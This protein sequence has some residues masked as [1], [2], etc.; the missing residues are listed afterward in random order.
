MVERPWN[1][2]MPAPQKGSLPRLLKE[3][4][5]GNVT[6][7][8]THSIQDRKTGWLNKTFH[9][10]FRE[11]LCHMLARYSAICPVYC[12][13]PDH[14]HMLITGIKR[15][16]NQLNLTKQLRRELNKLIQPYRLQSQA[17]DHVLREKENEKAAFQG[18]AY[19]IQ[20][21]PVRKNIS[22]QWKDHPYTGCQVPGYYDLD[23]R[24]EDYW[25]VF[26]R[27]HNKLVTT[28]S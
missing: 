6:V 5:Q 13:M 4:Y 21:N 22:K 18:I 26:W 14:M 12:L 27:I 2:S 3:A 17:H 10:Q 19:Y 15:S 24:K 23:P 20:Q 11:L 1:N 16:S 25:E 7:F 9:Y 28:T 8:W